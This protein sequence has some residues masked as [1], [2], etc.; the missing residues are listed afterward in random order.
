MFVIFKMICSLYYFKMLYNNMKPHISILKLLLCPLLSP[1][2][3]QKPL[4]TVIS[5]H[6][7]PILWSCRSAYTLTVLVE[8]PASYSFFDLLLTSPFLNSPAFQWKEPKSWSS[9]GSFLS[10]LPSLLC[11][12][13]LTK[14]KRTFKMIAK[15]LC[16]S[17]RICFLITKTEVTN[18]SFIPIIYKMQWL[19][20]VRQPLSLPP[21]LPAL[22]MVSHMGAVLFQ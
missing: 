17:H 7:N 13:R 8:H 20:W 22:E 4:S 10:L 9:L 6:H 19:V 15:V 16:C 2:N 1:M 12:T 5:F 3:C 18:V 14:V 11:F 21:L